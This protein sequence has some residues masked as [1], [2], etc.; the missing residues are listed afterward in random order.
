MALKLTNN[1]SGT[2]SA[3]ISAVAT[4]LTLQAGEGAEYPALGAGDWFP[5]VLEEGAAYEIV[6]VTA[7]AADT[8]TIVRG[9]EGTTAAS[10]GAAARADLR[11]TEAAMQA[12]FELATPAAAVAL[13]APKANPTLTGVVTV[14]DASFTP[15]KLAN[16]AAVSLLGRSANTSGVRADIAAA[17][18]DRV[19]RR[20]SDVIDFGQLTAGMFPN[21]ILTYAMLASS[22][23][24]ASGEFRAATASK[25]LNAAQ[26]WAD[27]D[28]APLTDAA[29]IVLSMSG[30]AT[31]A[32]VTL[33]GDRALANP[34]NTK[35]GQFFCIKLNATGATRTLTLGANFKVPAGV[36][37]F[38]ISIT[39]AETVYLCGFIESSTIARVTA[40]VRY[41]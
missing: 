22:A 23:Y 21:S 8:L 9:Q 30:I 20:V 38:P 12:L 7:R 39:T 15:A 2:L 29:S 26:V 27:A 17:A 18:N 41:T 11:L 37:S 33:G 31:M 35:N 40:V 32:S 13:L 34:T 16:G 19:A 10:F 1:A 28:F 4:T 6:R 14:P 36:E 3:S 5:L 24:I 25:L